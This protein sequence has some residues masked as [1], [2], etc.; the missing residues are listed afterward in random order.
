MSKIYSSFTFDSNATC[1][2][3]HLAKQQN[4]HYHSSKSIASHKFELLHIDIWGPLAIPYIHG[5]KYFLTII[6]D[7]TRFV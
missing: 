1:D 3:F 7:H 5:Q 4:F 6:D 2:I